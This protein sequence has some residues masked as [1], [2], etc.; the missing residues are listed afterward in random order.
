MRMRE[1]AQKQMNQKNME[2]SLSKKQIKK[3]WQIVKFGEIAKEVRSTT[4][5]AIEDGLEFYVGLE[6]LEPRSL[7]IQRKGLI[8]EDNPSFTRRFKAAQ[9][10]FGKRRCYQK[11]AAVPDFEGICSGDIIVME[12]VPEKII[13][14]LLPFI[15]QSDMFFDWA[16]KTSSGSLSPRTKWKAL[17]EFEFPL[18]PFERQK[19]IVEVL[20][21][22]EEID[23][24]FDEINKTNETIIAALQLKIFPNNFELHQQNCIP[25]KTGWK[26]YRMN[27]ILLSQPESGFSANEI[28]DVSKWHVLNLNC[29]CKTGFINNGYKPI[30][31]ESFNLSK[32]LKNRDFL[33][34]RSNTKD[35]VGLVGIYKENGKE[36][37]FPDTMIRLKINKDIILPEFLEM[38]LLSPYGRRQIVRLAAGTSGSMVKINKENIKKIPL[39][40]PSIHDQ[41]TILSAYRL[42]CKMRFQIEDQKNTNRL[43]KQSVLQQKCFLRCLN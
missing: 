17:A 39:P 23:S 3:G 14:E 28:A 11:K 22:N 36:A 10:L 27:E 19:E 7:R 12:A 29:L 42:L 35:L 5:T 40:I 20:E 15:V 25:L 41:S 18:P 13:P 24:Y 33:I 32:G 16:E 30:A 6:H 9:I 26:M 2:K 31:K 38:Y 34:S 4:Q 37:I 8:A 21:K 43:T 1:K